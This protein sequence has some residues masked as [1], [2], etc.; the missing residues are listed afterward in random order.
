MT[1]ARY[2]HGAQD[3]ASGVPLSNDVSYAHG[4]DGKD[5]SVVYSIDAAGESAKP[6]VEKVLPGLRERGMVETVMNTIQTDIEQALATRT[7]RT[8]RASRTSRTS[9]GLRSVSFAYHIE[10]PKREPVINVTCVVLKQPDPAS[11][12]EP[13]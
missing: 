5:G 6:Q 7:S 4:L 11:S 3:T 8:S 9:R 13:A 2:S 12:S 10:H 1:S